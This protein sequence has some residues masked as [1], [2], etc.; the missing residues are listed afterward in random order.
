MSRA[1]VKEDDTGSV[2]PPLIPPRPFLPKGVSNYVTPEGLKLL[3]E[4]MQ[5]LEKER[6]KI[7]TIKEDVLERSRQMTIIN[8]RIS[9]LQERINGAK[10]ID[11]A[12]QPKNEIR[13]GA[14]VILSSENGEEKKFR[15]TGVDEAA[16]NSCCVAFIAPIAKAVIG[17][18]K[19]E[20]ITIKLDKGTENFKV[21]SITY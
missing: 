1:F 8:G 14:E 19:G 6:S 12:N 13:F 15:I 17:K 3:K 18:K 4:E 11:P 10:I 2:P 20:K 9:L 7:E 21:D 16:R 5:E